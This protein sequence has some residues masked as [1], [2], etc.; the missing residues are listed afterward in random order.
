MERPAGH[1]EGTPATSVPGSGWGQPPWEIDF[2]PRTQPLPA[3][4]DVAIIGGGFTGLAAAAW[5]GRLSPGTKVAV[6]EAGALGAGASGRTGGVALD[7]TAAGPLP[8]LGAVLDAFTQALD[9]FQIQ[10]DLERTGAWEISRQ[11]GRADSPLAWQDSGVL[12]V[13]HEVSGATVD[14]A[15]LLTSL[16][17]AA[18]TCGAALYP[19]TR[20]RELRFEHPLRL[21]LHAATVRAS[22][23]LLAVNG[24]GFNLS[25]WPVAARAFFT[26]ATATAPLNHHQLQDL[27]EESLRP[28]YTIDLPYLWGRPLPGNRVLFGGGLVSVESEAELAALDVE[29]AQ[30]KQGLTSLQ[31]RVRGLVPALA[32]VEFSCSWGGPIL[33]SLSGRPFLCHHPQSSRVL[34][35]GGYTGQGI[36]QSVH[37]A[38]WA[39]EALLGRRPLPEWGRPDIA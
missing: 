20:V 25:P 8:G 37:L 4:V 24:T 5:L 35:L 38:R 1:R 15:S 22:Q 28:F 13:A 34:V 27:C 7:E 12:R 18:E 17:R 31:A 33:F 36:A 39:V 11:Q 32:S 19:H 23:V 9:E 10:C 29:Q 6:L 3:E 21:E 2:C 26:L 14:P 30:P 16:A